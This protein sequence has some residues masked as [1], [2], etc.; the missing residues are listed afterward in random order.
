ML[1]RSIFDQEAAGFALARDAHRAD[2]SIEWPE[3][4]WNC[5][6]KTG[7]MGWSIPTEYGGSD[8]D[9]GSLMSGYEAI[10][11]SC[12]TTAFIFSQREAAVRRIRSLGKPCLREEWLPRLATG[13]RH[14]TVGLSQLTTSRQHQGPS[15]VAHALGHADQPDSY[16]L[17]GEVPWV[18]A[19]DSS[20]AMIIGAC[21]DD[22]RQVLF[23][24]PTAQR[25]VEIDAP[26]AL[27]ALLGSRT[28]S[29]R[30]DH[31][32]I[33]ASLVLAGPAT[34]LLGPMTG[35]G[36]ETSCLALGLVRASVEHLTH[37]AIARPY[38]DTIAHRFES[39]L[40]DLRR[41][42]LSLIRNTLAND[43]IL[44]LRAACTRLALR[45]TQAVLTVSKG[46]GFIAPH[47]AQR[48]ARQ[49]LFFLV[50]S[51]PQPTATAL[52]SDLTPNGA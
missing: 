8:L 42:L 15:L 31:V 46:A 40:V 29:V 30:F 24:V 21:L 3:Q 33:P 32:E 6:I 11:A 39:N 47:P 38:L 4:S 51:C 12:L 37:E 36:L 20:D 1:Q 49:A 35:G 18:T 2:S 10:A 25:G 45:A 23:L 44:S 27:T 17:K 9:S 52:L 22:G 28:T 13:E 5:L 19:A 43:A 34:Q 7:A 14:V 48:W 50:W 16:L 41:R 26:M